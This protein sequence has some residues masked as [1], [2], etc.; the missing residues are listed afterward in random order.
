MKFEPDNL[1]SSLGKMTLS[2]LKTK[3]KYSLGTSTRD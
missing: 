1:Y 3:P 2:V